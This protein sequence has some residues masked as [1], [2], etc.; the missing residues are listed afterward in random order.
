MSKRHFHVR[1][2]GLG[3]AA[4]QVG[5]TIWI[6]IRVHGFLA[7]LAADGARRHRILRVGDRAQAVASYGDPGAWRRLSLQE[8]GRK[9]AIHGV[10]SAQAGALR[11]QG[12]Q[13]FSVWRPRRTRI[14]SVCFLV[15]AGTAGR[16]T[17]ALPLQ[18]RHLELSLLHLEKE[19]WEKLLLQ[20]I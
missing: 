11:R 3:A 19:E 2:A 5:S 16:L 9:A 14:F 7:A 20:Q 1:A 10:A 12:G 15:M 6:G 13:H 17:A 8:G 18:L 4:K